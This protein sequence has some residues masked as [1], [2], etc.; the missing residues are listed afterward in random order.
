MPRRIIIVRHGETDYNKQARFQGWSDQPLN[1]TGKKQSLDLCERLKNEKI[2]AIYSSDLKRVVQTIKP[3]SRKL[4]IKPI[5]TPKLREQNLGI[6]DG[7]TWQ[8]VNKKHGSLAKNFG[9]K[10]K[11]DWN[12]F[13]GESFNIFYQRVA[14][15]VNSVISKHKKTNIL[16]ATHGGT[17]Q[18]ILDR[19]GARKLKQ[20]V[21]IYNTAV[22]IT[23]KLK[24]GKYK[25]FLFNDANHT[26][27]TFEYE[28]I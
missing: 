23:V 13:K 24:T 17:K 21:P 7:L 12:G 28:D 15:F 4:E 8:E 11:R 14:D 26:H 2:D 20:F 16:I 6:F 9:N 25:I 3:L 22:T 18:V 27:Q 10:E 5:L 19:L 1:L